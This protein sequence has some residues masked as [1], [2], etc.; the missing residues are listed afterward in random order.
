VERSQEVL[1]A[2]VRAFNA[3]FQGAPSAQYLSASSDML[4]IGTDPNEWLVG[5][6]TAIEMLNAMGDSMAS[7]GVQYRFGNPEAWSEGDVGWVVDRPTVRSGTGQEALLRITT[8]WH[9]EEGNWKL[10]HEHVS[11]GVPNE[12]VPVFAGM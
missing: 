1:N 8:I 4:I 5:R 2:Y 7:G 12:Q 6:E 11:L 3:F 10:V 9:R